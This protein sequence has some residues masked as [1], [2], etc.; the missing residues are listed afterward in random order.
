MCLVDLSVS[1]QMLKEGL[2]LVCYWGE[3]HL[4]HTLNYDME[5]IA[6]YYCSDNSVLP[7]DII[8]TLAEIM[9]LKILINSVIS[10]QSHR[11]DRIS[12]WI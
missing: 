1:V 11:E 12:Y 5:I 8:L 4:I 3:N 2:K 6:S 9:E 10:F 7:F